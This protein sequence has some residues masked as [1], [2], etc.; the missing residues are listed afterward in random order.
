MILL[1]KS[2]VVSVSLVL[3]ESFSVV[4]PRWLYCRVG[5]RGEGERGLTYVT[6]NCQCLHKLV[7]NIEGQQ[8]V[9]MLVI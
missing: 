6:T 8:C 2:L 7:P 1:N 3:G 4:R 5:R 9:T